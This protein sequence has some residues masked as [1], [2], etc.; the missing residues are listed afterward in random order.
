MIQYVIAKSKELSHQMVKQLDKQRITY[1]VRNLSRNPFTY[2]EFIELLHLTERGTDEIINKGSFPY[3]H[4]Q[5]TQPFDEISIK[6]LHNLTIEYPSLIRTPFLVDFKKGKF[7]TDVS[8]LSVFTPRYQKE[9]VFLETL[10]KMQE[11][12]KEAVVCSSL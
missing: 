2:E 6:E 5:R 12:E 9:K 10:L 8:N 7:V 3:R 4:I 11:I 1:T